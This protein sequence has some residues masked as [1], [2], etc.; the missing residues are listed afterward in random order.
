MFRCRR[1]SGN[2]LRRPA[3]SEPNS[4]L[5]RRSYRSIHS[6]DKE[7]SRKVPSPFIL[8]SKA[9]AYLAGFCVMQFY[10]VTMLKTWC[11]LVLLPLRLYSWLRLR[12]VRR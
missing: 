5:L 2:S 10:V 8:R 6:G 1:G 12:E 7:F 9:V 11:D 3:V 4:Q